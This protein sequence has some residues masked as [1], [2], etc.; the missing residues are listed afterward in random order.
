MTAFDIDGVFW[1]PATP[2]SYVAGRLQF[3]VVDGGK[4]DLIGRLSGPHE[5]PSGDNSP[6]VIFG[7]AGKAQ[8]TLRQ[9]L[10]NHYTVSMP[11]I[12]RE[13]YLISEIFKGAHLDSEV[14]PEFV[15]L[16]VNIRYLSDWVARTG[17]SAGMVENSID[18][19]KITYARPPSESTQIDPG[20][21][22][23]CHGWESNGDGFSSAGLEHSTFIR[24]TFDTPQAIDRIYSTVLA[25]QDLVT[26]GMDSTAVAIEVILEHTQHTRELP[27]GSTVHDQIELII[28][29]LGA[30]VPQPKARARPDDILM[31]Y[32]RF[33]R[34]AGVASWLE[35]RP[36]FKLTINSLLSHRYMPKMYG[37]NRLQNAVFAAE[38]FDRARFVNRVQPKPIFRKRRDRI[39]DACP[40]DRDWL[41]DILQYANEPRLLDRLLRL[42]SH[43][44]SRFDNLVQDVDGWA[45]LVK[46]TRN[47]LV[48]SQAGDDSPEGLDLFLLS[49][50]VYFLVVL[51]LLKECGIDEVVLDEE[52]ENRRYC[53]LRDQLQEH[54][55]Y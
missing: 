24:L 26:L 33:G 23:V 15:S 55:E 2:E 22:E 50:S 30:D 53:Q 42:A 9:C 13:A 40:D 28:P 31:T 39:L 43:A 29:W 17:I 35:I 54:L 12:E 11:G 1:D 37:E 20:T 19:F 52:F 49:E 46:K 47:R 10:P 16:R 3:D 25:L 34:I 41:R 48:H 14:A 32:D 36:K 6:K 44:G 8:Y 5:L 4:L 45:Q 18:D 38:S 27:S 51:C 21:I 7:V